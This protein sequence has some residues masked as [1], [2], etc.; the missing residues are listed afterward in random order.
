MN[1]NMAWTR[2]MPCRNKKRFQIDRIRLDR[3]RVARLWHQRR[4][5]FSHSFWKRGSIPTKSKNS[6]IEVIRISKTY[7]SPDSKR[8]TISPALPKSV[9]I[10]IMGEINCKEPILTLPS[11]IQTL[12]TAR[13]GSSLAPRLTNSY[14]MLRRIGAEILVRSRSRPTC[15]TSSP[16]RIGYRRRWA[17]S[18]IQI[19]AI[20]G[21]T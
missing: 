20:V 16:S 11:P 8:R 2:Q 12:E 9:L 17:H 4:W 19:I 15:K 1:K 7:P 10:R 13:R 21:T 14:G 6:H 3:Q 18:I 5:N